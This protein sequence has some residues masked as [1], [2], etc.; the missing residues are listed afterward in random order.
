MAGKTKQLPPSVKTHAGPLPAKPSNAMISWV[1]GAGRSSQTCNALGNSIRLNRLR[2]SVLA[3]AQR[4]KH[5]GVNVAA[6]NRIS[7]AVQLEA[8]SV[9]R[10]P[11]IITIVL[12]AAGH[13]RFEI[14]H[15]T[16]A[17]S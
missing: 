11:G 17:R 9:L 13:E 8:V 15:A 3:Q 7:D 10:L 5:G 2:S 4:V 16:I 6:G 12:A 14:R 1:D